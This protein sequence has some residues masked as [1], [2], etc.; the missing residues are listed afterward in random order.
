MRK[1][2]VVSGWYGPGNIG[3]EAILQAI[4][5]IFA[6]EFP[7]AQITVLSLNPAYTRK[8]QNVAAVRQVPAGCRSWLTSLLSFDL[9]RTLK[10]IKECDLFV[11]G[12]GGFLSDLQPEVPHQWLRQMRLAK[13]FGAETWLY[14][15]GA[16]PFV[17][18]KG[19]ATTRFYLD[20]YVDRIVVRDRE[21]C[22]QLVEIVKTRHKPEIQIDPVAAMKVERFLSADQGEEKAISL[23]YTEYFNNR[24]FDEI[25]RQKWPQ[26]FAA[27]CA[28][29]EAVLDSGYQARL[30]FFQKNIET[31]LAAEFARVFGDRVQMQFPLDYKEALR[32]LAASRA[33]VSFR[34][35]GNIL[36]Y[37]LKKPFLPIIYHH[38]TAGFLE[39]IDYPFKDCILEAG[40]GNSWPNCNLDP[41]HWAD[42]TAKFL[43]QPAER[44]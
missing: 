20:N 40:D 23:I 2:I 38:K 31:R 25:Q 32:F 10:A 33:V 19:R 1:K 17:S 21:S 37:A 41:A 8:T 5:D 18:E 7:G 27:Y 43:Q 16:G 9:L 44:Q 24:C 39:Q 3:D 34:L 14:R 15:I 11:M 30:V 29:I 6:D 36:A 42:N 35:H 22:R 4:I 13:F 28:Q 12:G 26:L